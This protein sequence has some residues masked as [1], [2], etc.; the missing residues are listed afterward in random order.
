MFALRDHAN[1]QHLEPEYEGILN[2]CIFFLSRIITHNVIFAAWKPKKVAKGFEV[3][4]FAVY[5][6]YPPPLLTQYVCNLLKC[7]TQVVTFAD[8]VAVLRSSSY[9]LAV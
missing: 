3:M 8:D 9:L 2:I 4:W 7:M 5:I 1:W 6:I